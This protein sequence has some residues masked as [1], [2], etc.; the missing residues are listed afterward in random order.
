MIAR[1]IFQYGIYPVITL[2][3]GLLYNLFNRQWKQLLFSYLAYKQFVYPFSKS[4]RNKSKFLLI[5]PL[6]LFF[7]SIYGQSPNDII[8]MWENSDKKIVI[9]LFKTNNTFSAKVIQSTT[10]SHIGRVIVWDLKY[11]PK[12]N[13]W[14]GGYVQKPEM[15]H[16]ASC[17]IVLNAANS[18]TITGY[19]GLRIFGKSEKFF[20]KDM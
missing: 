6:I 11:N 16:S 15:E 10:A 5:L 17:F 8:G 13:E 18:I 4:L 12:E 14:S 19:H 9:E 20:R 2:T 7:K 1:K 3:A